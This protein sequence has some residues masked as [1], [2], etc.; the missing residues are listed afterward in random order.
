[1][2]SR[3]LQVY[4]S[5]SNDFICIHLHASFSWEW[6]NWLNFSVDLNG[7]GNVIHFCEKSQQR[8]FFTFLLLSP[9]ENIYQG[10]SIQLRLRRQLGLGAGMRSIGCHFLVE[11][12]ASVT[13]HG[14][15]DFPPCLIAFRQWMSSC[16]RYMSP[17][18][19][20][21]VWTITQKGWCANTQ[22][23]V[24]QMQSQSSSLRPHWLLINFMH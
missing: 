17:I 11:S 10:G 21:F 20:P 12:A 13:L 15:S 1:M 24:Q 23:H 19:V 3:C 2:W 18:C 6:A 7:S 8:V 5:Q 9:N 16:R 4:L 22:T 14:K